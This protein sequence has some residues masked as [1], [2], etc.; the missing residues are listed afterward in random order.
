MDEV[1]DEP[2]GRLHLDAGWEAWLRD[3][4]SPDAVPDN[5]WKWDRTKPLTLA[6]FICHLR[7]RRLL[8]DPPSSGSE[9]NVEPTRVVVLGGNPEEEENALA[10]WGQVL[11]AALPQDRL[12]LLMIGPQV[13]PERHGTKEQ[14]TPQLRL[15]FH[16]GRFHEY[17]DELVDSKAYHDPDLVV[18]FHR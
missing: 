3:C 1:R 9:E 6:W 8:L 17:R 15:E 12:D 11:G 5:L 10:F 18:A 4:A 16:R 7:H 2:Q 14:V 13:S